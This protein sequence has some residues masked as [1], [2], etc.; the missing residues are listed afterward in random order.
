MVLLMLA[1]FLLPHREALTGMVRL[2]NHSP[3][4]SYGWLVPAISLFLLWSRRDALRT[5]PAAPAPRYGG[6]VLAGWFVLLVA[7]KVAGNV[8]LQQIAI[9]VG[10]AGLVLAAFGA[11]VL[12]ATWVPI[13]YL[14]LAVPLWDGF[15]EPLHTPFQNLSAS[16][17]AWILSAVGI[18]AL[19]AGTFLEL[20][21]L[22]LEVARACSEW[23]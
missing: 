23:R 16:I 13:A 3:M 20:P 17:G 1:G 12:R 7:G 6:L 22:Q 15:T 9:V 8:L 18:P 19:R 14:L 2:W 10:V 4:Y 5:V 21:G 11:R